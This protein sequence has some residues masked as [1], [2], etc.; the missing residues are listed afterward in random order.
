MLDSEEKTGNTLSSEQLID[1]V[2]KQKVRIKRLEKE[3]ENLVKLNSEQEQQIKISASISSTEIDT[4]SSS[5]NSS[6]L[7]WGLIERESIFQ[8]KLAKTALNLLVCTITKSKMG[9]RYIPSISSLFDRW[10]E[11]IEQLK[12][13]TVKNDLLDSSKSILVL[14]QKSSKL[15]ALLARTHQVTILSLTLTLTLTLILILII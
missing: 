11:R 6:S 15:K 5:N 14:E 2:K 13:Q 1:Y 9:K 3:K 12:L 7:Y 10:K 4:K 8:Q